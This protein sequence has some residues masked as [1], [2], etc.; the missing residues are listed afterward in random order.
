LSRKGHAVRI[1]DCQIC[2]VVGHTVF[3]CVDSSVD[4]PSV[5]VDADLIDGAAAGGLDARPRHGKRGG[6]KTQLRHEFEVLGQA[7]L[8]AAERG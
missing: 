2:S 4:K 5:E 6:A 3:E 7:V 8:A 1:L